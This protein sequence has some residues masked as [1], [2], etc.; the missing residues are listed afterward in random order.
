M[1][2][3]APKILDRRRLFT[4]ASGAALLGSLGLASAARA[5]G[6]RPAPKADKP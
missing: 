2:E 3:P 6:P 1:S 5:A 4:V